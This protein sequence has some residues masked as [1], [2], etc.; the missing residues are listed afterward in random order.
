MVRFAD[1]VID[2]AKQRATRA[3]RPLALTPQDLILLA[4]LVRQAG[5]AVSK[6]RLSREIWKRPHDGRS[7]FVEVGVWRLRSKLDDP[8]DSKLIHAVRGVGY[9]CAVRR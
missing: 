7:N 3:G 2:M 6:Q 5:K 8:F 1:V 9:V 4:L